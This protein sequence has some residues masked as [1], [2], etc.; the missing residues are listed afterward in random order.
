MSFCVLR[1]APCA[2]RRLRLCARLAACAHTPSQSRYCRWQY[3]LFCPAPC[4]GRRLRLCARLAAC[5]HTPSQSRYCRW[6]YAFFCPAP[7]AGRRLRLCARLAACAH[8][9]SQSRY[10]R[11]QYARPFA[12]HIEIATIACASFLLIYPVFCENLRIRMDHRNLTETVYPQK[13]RCDNCEA[14][15]FGSIMS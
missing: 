1:P 12:H 11:W 15:G 7:C 9:P 8:T 14:I 3:A 4:A 10:C 2:G 5:A 13:R 6:Q